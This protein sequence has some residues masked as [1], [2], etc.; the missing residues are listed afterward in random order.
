[1]GRVYRAWDP[2]VSRVVAVKTV[3]T[4]C[5]TGDTRDEFLKRDDHRRPDPRLA[6][7]HRAG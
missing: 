4:E 6:V 1:M 7:P 5:L 2:A 3:K